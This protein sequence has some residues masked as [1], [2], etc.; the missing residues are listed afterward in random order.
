MWDN[1]LTR[2]LDNKMSKRGGYALLLDISNNTA[3]C[4]E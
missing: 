4:N 3:E 1:Y 2:L